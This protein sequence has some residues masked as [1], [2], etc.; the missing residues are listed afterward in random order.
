MF[1]IEVS[2]V[3]KDEALSALKVPSIIF[4]ANA[5]FKELFDIHVHT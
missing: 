4:F 3:E 2:I 5:N 1:F